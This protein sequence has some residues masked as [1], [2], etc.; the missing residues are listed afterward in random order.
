MGVEEE[1]KSLQGGDT[2]QNDQTTATA[3]AQPPARVKKKSAPSVS[4]KSSHPMAALSAE[5]LRYKQVKYGDIVQGVI[6]RVAS[7]EILVDIGTK[8]EASVATKEVDELGREGRDKIHIGDEILAFVLR[9]EDYESGTI[10]SLMRAQEER[11]WRDAQSGLDSGAIIEAQVAGYNKGGLIVR[12]GKVR[13]FVPASQL[14][15]AS[16]SRGDRELSEQDLASFVGKKLKLKIIEIDRARSRLIL[17]ER[18]AMREVRRDAKVRLMEEIRE[19]DTRSGAVTSVAD[20]GVFV[21]L[22]GVD[23]LIHVSELSWTKVGHP[24]EVVKVGDVVNVKVLG[25]DRDK[26]RIALSIK[27][28]QAEPWTTIEERYHIG[29]LVNATITKLASFGAFARVDEGIEGLIH[30][31]ELSERRISHPKEVVK[32]GDALQL[33]VIKIDSA[34]RRLGLSLKRVDDEEYRE[35]NNSAETTEWTDAEETTGENNEP[36]PAEE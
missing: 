33:R 14:D 17:S 18:N 27:R 36:G 3:P 13:G 34:R 2:A 35:Y 7:H 29:D 28:L 30:V 19:G 6:V 26:N 10:L 21:D 15:I 22:G 5:E 1:A 24:G 16:R 4:D 9:P 31:S 20:F 11:D 23:G 32:E 25:I 12:V 8:S